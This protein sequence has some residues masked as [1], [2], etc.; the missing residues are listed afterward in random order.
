M[1]NALIIRYLLISA[2]LIFYLV[3]TIRY[4][5]VF[6]KNKIFTGGLK[7]FHLIMIWPIPFIWIF[8]LKSLTKFSPGSHEIKNTNNTKPFSD[9]NGD[10]INASNIGF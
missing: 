10:A 7:T 6:R 3:F 4:F 5:F 8:L 2:T 1:A 9:N